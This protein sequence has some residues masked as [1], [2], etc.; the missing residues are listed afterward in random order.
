MSGK[1]GKGEMS[2]NF[3]LRFWK[4]CYI[5]IFILKI[6]WFSNCKLNF[7]SSWLKTL[8]V[9]VY[10]QKSSNLT[11]GIPGQKKPLSFIICLEILGKSRYS[12]SEMFDVVYVLEA[13]ITILLLYILSSDILTSIFWIEHYFLIFTFT[14]RVVIITTLS[15]HPHHPI[16]NP[17]CPCEGIWWHKFGSILA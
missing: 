5:R 15:I 3:M 13:R 11:N 16:V 8:V 10:K 2:G 17:L 14:Q 4:V 12:G 6:T 7:L 1:S 9:L